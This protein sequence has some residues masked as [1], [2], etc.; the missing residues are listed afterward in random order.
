LHGTGFPI[1]NGSNVSHGCMRIDNDD[2][3]TF[4]KVAPNHGANTK[5]IV[6]S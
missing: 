3:E 5:I 4:Y 6:S 2:I 1:L